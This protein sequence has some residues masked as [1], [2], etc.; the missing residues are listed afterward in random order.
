MANTYH[1][2]C[3]NVW[4]LKTNNTYNKGDITTIENKYGK[5]TEVE[6][7]NLINKELQETNYYS[8]VR[9]EEKSYYERKVETQEKYAKKNREQAKKYFEKSEEHKEFLSM[10]EPIKV[11][12]H[13]ENRHRKICDDAWNNLG[14]SI[15]T[16]ALAKKQEA[17]AEYYN[18]KAKEITLAMPESLEKFK[19]D[20]EQAKE[21]QK[22]YKE[23]KTKRP[24]S[25]SLSYA[26]KSVKDLTSKVEIAE[27]LWGFN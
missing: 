22:I 1:K 18:N 24:H 23:D 10:G 17:K 6:I 19:K 25:Y 20:L 14:K 12:H 3:P 4:V 13:S 21:I 9:I 15:K 16:N 11:G 2:L 8:F 26:N 27:L 7:Y 5:E